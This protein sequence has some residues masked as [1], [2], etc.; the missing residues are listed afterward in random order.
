LRESV[1]QNVEEKLKP[2]DNDQSLFGKLGKIGNAFAAGAAKQIVDASLT[3]EGL[4][5]LLRHHKKN[6]EAEKSKDV[7]SSDT[8]SDTQFSTGYEGLNQFRV[9]VENK[10]NK[11]QRLHLLFYRQSLFGWRL[12][13]VKF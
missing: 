3:P 8:S 13:A 10:Q 7:N 9:T 4:A 2:A 11:L 1:K 12:A 6:Q 5:V